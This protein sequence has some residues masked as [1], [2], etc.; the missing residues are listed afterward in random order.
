[1]VK[2]LVLLL[3]IYLSFVAF[4]F[5]LEKRARK[6][7]NKFLKKILKLPLISSFFRAEE[8]GWSIIVFETDKKIQEL[9][10]DDILNTKPLNF[11]INEATSIAD[12]FLFEKNDIQYLFFEVEYQKHL[13]KKADI[14]HAALSRSGNW[15]YK[16]LVLEEPFHQSFPLIFEHEDEVYMIP[17]SF[18][19]KKVI[20]YK[21]L[22]FPNTWELEYELLT[23]ESYVDTTFIKHKGLF[24]WFTTNLKNDE[25]ELF[26]SES[27][28]T[29]WKKHPKSP[30]SMEVSNNR[31]AGNIF[32]ENDK[33]FR[34]A[35]DGREGYGSGIVLLQIE[36][37][38]TENYKEV[39]VKDP[40]LYKDEG[41]C[42]DGLHHLSFLQKQDKNMIAIDGANFS[43]RKIRIK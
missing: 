14:G 29:P 3:F 41:F 30:I 19:S 17:E 39:I 13:N 26:Y 8:K 25:L 32:L 22:Q 10:N 16:G 4:N 15:E 27:L 33:M 18:E 9:S 23:G 42:K 20:L 28:T 31:N 35:Q 38:D 24:F 6:K 43:F 21:A 36:E 12:P 11:R 37:L 34:L 7:S 1:M 5:W 40:L 2:L